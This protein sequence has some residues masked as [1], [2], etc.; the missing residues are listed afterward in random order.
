MDDLTKFS[1]IGPV[2]A[3]KLNRIGV[4]TLSQLVEIGSVDATIQIGNKDTSACI[5]MLYALEGAIR[6][7]RW[8]SIPKEDREKIKA[9]FMIAISG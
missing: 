2:L 9:E 3:V 8:H 5:N 6:G 7:V 4:M 1:N